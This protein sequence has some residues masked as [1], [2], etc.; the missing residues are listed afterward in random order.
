MELVTVEG[1]TKHQGF[2]IILRQLVWQGA[3]FGFDLLA[4]WWLFS[5]QLKLKTFTKEK[6]KQKQICTA[7][8]VTMSAETV[9]L[10]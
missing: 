6:T 4:F 5:T 7:Y 9:K 8:A 2:I 10:N 1:V 3:C